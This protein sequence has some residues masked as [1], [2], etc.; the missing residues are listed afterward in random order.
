M[1]AAPADA[2]PIETDA[3]IIG[4]GPVGLFQVFELGLLEIQAHV[5][6]ALPCAGGQCIELYPDKPIYDIPALPVC[7]GR[8]LT[9]RLLQQIAPFNAT[10]HFGHE[11]TQLQRRDDGRFDLATAA[12]TRF[13][14]KTVFIAGGVGAFQ[15]RLLKVEGLDRFRDTQLFYRVQQPAQF[16]GLRLVI[17]GGG[18]SAVDWALH[19]AAPDSP[20]R[21]ASVT[22]VHRRDAFTAAPAS[23]TRLRTLQESDALQLQI[24]QV[25]GIETAGD[26]LT[27]VTVTAPDGSA[28]ALPCDAVLVFFGLSPRL[29]PIADWGLALERRQLAVNPAT[30]ETSEPGVFA[31]GDVA[32]YPGKRKLILCGFHEATLA[33]FAAAPYVHPE[34]PVQLQYT[35]A[36]PRL[37]QLL[38][39]EPA[40]ADGD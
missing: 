13:I 2:T 21:A 36:S 32:T 33:A 16:A 14:A 27:A 34:R 11:A 30:S 10:F 17:V 6:D 9:E 1:S 18:D 23:V 12:G 15:P 3:V 5:I 28:T 38:G 19:F 35:T 22:L 4:A 39:V 29:G 8:E 7:S 40:R 20:H 25:S 24:G 37:H 26:R 31:V